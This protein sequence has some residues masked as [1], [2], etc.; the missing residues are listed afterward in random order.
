[1]SLCNNTLLANRLIITKRFDFASFCIHSINII[2]N[3]FKLIFRLITLK[4]KSRAFKISKRTYGFHG[5]E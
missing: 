4:E 1:M 3:A 5:L 2:A